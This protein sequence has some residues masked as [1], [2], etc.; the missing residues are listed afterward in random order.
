MNN[1]KLLT[2]GTFAF[3]FSVPPAHAQ[4]NYSAFADQE[5]YQQ[6]TNIE[7]AGQSPAQTLPLEK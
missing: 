5:H 3:C 4:F 2:V 7:E 1:F 6:F